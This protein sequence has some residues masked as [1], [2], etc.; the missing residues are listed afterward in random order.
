MFYLFV[1]LYLERGKRGRETLV[2]ER[3]SYRLPFTCSQL[4][5]WPLIQACALTRSQTSDLL[6]CK[7]ITNPLN[8]TSSVLIDLLRLS[9]IAY[10]DDH[11]VIK[12]DLFLSFIHIFYL[13]GY[14]YCSGF[15]IQSNV[16]FTRFSPLSLEIHFGVVDISELTDSWLAGKGA[17]V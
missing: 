6:V 10:I 12:T 1:C 17:L 2:C 11:I 16:L 7:T 14:S 5:T 8:H 4:G 9:Y 3:N 15:G 13:F